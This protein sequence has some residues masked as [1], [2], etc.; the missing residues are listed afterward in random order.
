MR[1]LNV[2]L[3]LLAAA[4]TILTVVERNAYFV[5]HALLLWSWAAVAIRQARDE[6]PRG[7]GPVCM[8]CGRAGAGTL[9]DGSC[10]RCAHPPRRAPGRSAK[11]S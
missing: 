3:L 9:P 7:P 5:A 4:V 1:A 10:A 6:D 8:G 11:G 2:L